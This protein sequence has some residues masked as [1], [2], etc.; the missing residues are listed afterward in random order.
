MLG[1]LARWLRILGIDTFYRRDITD[2]DL[3]RI[4]REEDRLILTRDTGLA[5]KVQRVLRCIFVNSDFVK[6]QLK[7]V[8]SEL[9]ERGFKF[10]EPFTRCPVCNGMLL[11]ITKAE[12]LGLVPDYIYMKDFEFSRCQLCNRIY[13]PGSHE[14]KIRE[15]ISKII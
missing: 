12:A 10:P 6:E 8:L 15:F 5:L 4:A 11:A 14:N 3:I 9:R 1:R 13:W 2:R 7:Q